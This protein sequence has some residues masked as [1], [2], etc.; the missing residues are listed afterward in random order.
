[1]P[2]SPLTKIVDD[3]VKS[4]GLNIEIK[5]S[6]SYTITLGGRAVQIEMDDEGEFVIVSALLGKVPSGMYRQNVLE[7]ALKSN[8]YPPPH[9]GILGFDS[10]SENLVLHRR[11]PLSKMTKKTLIEQLPGFI[12]MA[13]NWE[14]AL[15]SSATPIASKPDPSQAPDILEILGIKR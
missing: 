5:D 3:L 4:L 11:F 8:A 2:K 14:R 9:F 6:P 12:E 10:S 7:Q 13:R 15:S 1:M